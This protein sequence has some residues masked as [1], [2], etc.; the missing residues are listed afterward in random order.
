MIEV[1]IEGDSVVKTDIF[2][3]ERVAFNHAESEDD[4]SSLL[5]PNKE[6]HLV[7]HQPPDAAKIFLCQLLKVKIR[8]RVDLK[9]EGVEVVNEGGC[10]AHN[11]HFDGG[12]VC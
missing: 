3:V 4:W 6:A 7:R 8:S 9:I 10:V 5:A 11:A 1:Q 12:R 2:G